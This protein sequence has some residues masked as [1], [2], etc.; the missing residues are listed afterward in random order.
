MSLDFGTDNALAAIDR[1]HM[2]LARLKGCVKAMFGNVR[3]SMISPGLNF[4][5]N[6]QLYHDFSGSPV[7]CGQFFE[8]A[9]RTRTARQTGRCTLTIYVCVSPG[10]VWVVRRRGSRQARI[11]YKTNFTASADVYETTTF[12]GVGGKFD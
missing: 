2:S 10:C 7:V 1:T 6:Q 3:N 9:I 5:M 12:E 11:L 4:K 8:R